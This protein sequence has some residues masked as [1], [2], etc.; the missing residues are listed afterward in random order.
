MTKF[1]FLPESNRRPVVYETTALPSELKKFAKYVIPWL[2]T[3]IYESELSFFVI[4]LLNLLQFFI[5]YIMTV[6]Y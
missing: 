4:R 6:I 1:S 3:I 2:L 5:S